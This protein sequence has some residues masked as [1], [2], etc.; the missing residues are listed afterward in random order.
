MATGHPADWHTKRSPEVLLKL[1]SDTR[2]YTRRLRL[3]GCACA[4]QVWH[5]LPTD[6]RSAVQI[7]ERL[8][9]GRATAIDMR[10]AAVRLVWAAVTPGQ[11]AAHAAGYAS[12]G[13]PG[14][15]PPG[16]GE[17][18]SYDPRQAA[19]LAAQAAATEAI[20][21]AP[22]GPVAPDWW[23]DAWN[24]AYDT[25]REIQADYVR[26]IFPPPGYTPQLHPDWLTST[27]LALARQMD[28]SDDFSAVPILADAL[29]DAGCDIEA[30]LQCSRVPGN[31]HVR[32]NWVVDLVLGR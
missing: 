20:G 32:G 23:Q 22:V 16:F 29:Q 3:F 17:V 27:V 9:E 4:R 30:M 2:G 28:E 25:A 13:V 18:L 21:P 6:A 5:L 10:A 7:S 26:D 31:V 15:A 1:V 8:A 19:R 12:C 14:P 11:I 24:T